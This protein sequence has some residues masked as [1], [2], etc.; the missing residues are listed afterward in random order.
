[1]G[2]EKLHIQGTGYPA[3]TTPGPL[4]ACQ[5][6]TRERAQQ[7][8]QSCA[9]ACSRPWTERSAESRRATG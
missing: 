5:A 6:H 4:A 9:L 7:D 1:M 8:Q 3:K 2:D